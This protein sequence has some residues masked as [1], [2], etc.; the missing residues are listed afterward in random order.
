MTNKEAH[1]Y[2]ED[3][4]RKYTRDRYLYKPEF[5]EANGLA[6]LAL[7][8]QIPKKVDKYSRCPSCG[9]DATNQADN[10]YNFEYCYYCGQALDWGE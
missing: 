10:D 2:L 4:Q 7:E 9:Y 6:I 5:I 1:S 3:L 8:K